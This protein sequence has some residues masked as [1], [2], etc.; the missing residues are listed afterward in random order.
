MGYNC[1]CFPEKWLEP[2]RTLGEQG[3]T[4]TTEITLR[5]KTFLFRWQCGYHRPGTAECHLRTGNLRG[6]SSSCA[7]YLHYIVASD[8]GGIQC[9]N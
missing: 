3:V 4:E 9:A 1:L 8:S 5:R 7:Q 6:T 2:E